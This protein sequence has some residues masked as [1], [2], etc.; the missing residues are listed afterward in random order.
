MHRRL[1]VALGFAAGGLLVAEHRRRRAAER[2]GAAALETI[3]NTIEANDEQTG[4]HVRRVA[5]YALILSDAA[6]FE[7]AQRRSIERVALFHDIGKI[8]A[9]LYDIVH[10]KD[11]LSPAER[12]AIA[13][14]PARGAEVL[15]PLA[16]FYPKLTEGVYSHH[17]RWDGSGY[18]R[19]LR[20]RRIPMSA[21]VVAIADTFDAVA[22]TRHY[23]RGRGFSVAADVIAAGRGTEFDPELVDLFLLPPVMEQIRAVRLPIVSERRRTA[24]RARAS[25][26]RDG[27]ERELVPDIR[28]RWRS[29]GLATTPPVQTE[30]STQT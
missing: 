6:G 11:S 13:T 19:G 17:E 7:R 22:A 12:R 10:D 30:T 29:E 20:G 24:A 5:A 4:M 8:H 2:F 26:R 1:A 15:A 16:N 27:R 14:H 18:P 3:L 21:R 9:A 25:E 28:F 23:R